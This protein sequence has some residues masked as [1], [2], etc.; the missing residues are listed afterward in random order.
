MVIALHPGTGN[1]P[2]TIPLEPRIL[3]QIPGAGITTLDDGIE[4][5]DD[6][7]H[8]GHTITF[9]ITTHS[10]I[11]PKDTVCQVYAP[12]PCAYPPTILSCPVP[13]ERGVHKYVIT[14]IT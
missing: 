12:L 8:V 1:I 5:L 9:P 13:D 2:L 14:L 7:P 4:D 11:I 10:P 3:I 6:T